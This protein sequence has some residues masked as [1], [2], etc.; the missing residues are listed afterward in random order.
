MEKLL[1]RVDEAAQMLGLGRTK[2]YELVSRGDLPS[3]TV[4][5]SRRIPA[6][7]LRRWVAARSAAGGCGGDAPAPMGPDFDAHF[8]QPPHGD[9]GPTR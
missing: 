5:T 6:E 9:E 4:G 7:D 8:A 1:L 2:V 3:I